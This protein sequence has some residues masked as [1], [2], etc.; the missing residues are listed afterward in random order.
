MCP[1]WP[2]TW[3]LPKKGLFVTIL[4]LKNKGFFSPL[5]IGN[6]S[7][8]VPV[9]YNTCLEAQKARQKQW[10]SGP[11]PIYFP[12][13]WHY[14]MPFLSGLGKKPQTNKTKQ[15]NHWA[16]RY[17]KDKREKRQ[18]ELHELV[19]YRQPKGPQTREHK[20]HTQ[21]A[22]QTK[23]QRN[24]NQFPIVTLHWIALK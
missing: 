1:S 4:T 19:G 24:I 16:T 14:N 12:A 6:S 11:I 21:K 9:D 8:T 3:K 22:Q 18:N 2:D 17:W 23:L 10:N 15:Q 13:S 20:S 5:I 7:C